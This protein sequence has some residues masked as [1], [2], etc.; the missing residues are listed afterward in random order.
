MSWGTKGIQNR[1]FIFLRDKRD[2]KTSASGVINPNSRDQNFKS[3]TS[4]KEGKSRARRK[5]TAKYFKE[6]TRGG[7][8]WAKNGPLYKNTH[9]QRK[10]RRWKLAVKW[11]VEDASFIIKFVYMVILDLLIN[12]PSQP[13]TFYSF[14]SFTAY[15]KVCIYA[16][17]EI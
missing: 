11:I 9:L 14:T 4:S 5:N 7:E 3:F 10:G 12:I 13:N 16:Y 15:L 17:P 6:Q 1:L 2:Y 8:E